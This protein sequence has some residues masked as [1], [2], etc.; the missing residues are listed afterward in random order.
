[1]VRKTLDELVN[2]DEPAIN[3]IH[4]WVESAENRCEI[5]PPSDANEEVLL[6]IQVT[7]RSPLG[8]LAYETGG[9]LVDHGW[10]RFLGS[11]HPKLKRTLP[12]WNRRRMDG[13]YLVA[14]DVVG[15]FFAINGGALGEDLNNIYYWPPD[16][17][18]W[19]PLEIG[20]TELFCW[21]LT[22][23]LSDF[24]RELRWPDWK[25]DLATLSGDF[26]FSFYPFL[27]TKEG[28]IAGSDRRP[29]PVAEAFDL[30]VDFV[31]QLQQG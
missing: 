11:G 29:V 2:R 28:S 30:K 1:M 8:A 16:R 27:W 6:E 23:K 3:L 31:R 22:S 25:S 20:F 7:T 4:D 12:V 19:E 5:L 21:S 14:D 10:I 26:C 9:V 17:L 13:L 24:Y 18:E 15:G